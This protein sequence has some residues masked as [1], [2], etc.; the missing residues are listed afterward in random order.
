MDTSAALTASRLAPPSHAVRIVTVEDSRLGVPHRA[1]S[2]LKAT[3]DHRPK[4]SDRTCCGRVI[5]TLEGIK[6]ANGPNLIVKE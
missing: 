1:W 5:E 3:R 4:S 6:L 2:V